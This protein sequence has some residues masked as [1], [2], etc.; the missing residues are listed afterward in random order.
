MTSSL[1]KFG[2]IAFAILIAAGAIYFLMRKPIPSLYINEILASST[3]C[4]PDQSSGQ[5][6][7]DDWIEIYNASAEPINMGGMY[8]SQ[9]KKKPLS[10]LILATDP[11]LTTIPPGGHLL[12]WADGSPEQGALHLKFKLNQEGEYI[13]LFNKDGRMIDELKFG[14]QTVNHSYGRVTDGS[15]DWKEFSEPTPGIANR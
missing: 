4:C 2:I 14:K 7:F 6:E 8:F 12:L 15:A 3:S 1:N 13:G 5:D 9:N 11:Q 10:Y